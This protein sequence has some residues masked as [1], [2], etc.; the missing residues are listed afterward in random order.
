MKFEI[1]IKT[2][3]NMKTKIA[4]ILL[5]SILL[6]FCQACVND[7]MIPY[8]EKQ[9][10][11]K[12]VIKAYNAQKDSIQIAV[13][14]KI[15]KEGK[16][17]AYIKKISKEH[18]FVF[19]GDKDKVVEI[20]NK[21]T[22]QL[23]YSYKLNTAKPV[24]TI[25]FYTKEEVWVENVLKTKPGKITQTGYAGFKFIF[26]TLNKYSASGY[27]GKLDGIMRKVNGEVVGTVK[28]IGK[29]SYSDFIEF[30]ASLPPIIRMELVKHNTTESY[31]SGKQVITV[32][33]M[34]SNKSTLI[35]LDERK[36]ANGKFSN[37]DASLNLADH[38]DF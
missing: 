21:A 32:M 33:L 2:N 23:I 25:S 38:F 5:F 29:D 7:E 18:E 15:L 20:T 12:V 30:P 28:N 8:Y 24:D 13:D 6:A 17:D 36:D 35:V 3:I 27:T 31:I 10:P 11:G 16:V 26:P 9:Q 4:K 37:V 14:G 1:I 22:K 34:T 19:Y